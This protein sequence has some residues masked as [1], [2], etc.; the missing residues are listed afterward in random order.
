M[1]ADKLCTCILMVMWAVVF[2]RILIVFIMAPNLTCLL[3]LFL[4]VYF[5]HVNYITLKDD[6]HNKNDNQRD[7]E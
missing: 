6:K 4:C 2:V 1:N 3:I 5:F 7:K